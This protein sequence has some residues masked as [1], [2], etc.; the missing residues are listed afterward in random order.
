MQFSHS[1]ID[2]Q[3]EGSNVSVHVAT[4]FLKLPE[5]ITEY[6]AT[7]KNQSREGKLGETHKDSP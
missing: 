7:P 5:S 2:A 6:W 3:M 1:N 4:L